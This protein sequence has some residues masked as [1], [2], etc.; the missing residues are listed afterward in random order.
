ML[1]ERAKKKGAVLGVAPPGAGKSRCMFELA[2]REVANGGR[3]VIKAHRKM[4]LDQLVGSFQAAGMDV[5]VISP[6][7][8]ANDAARV[9]I[10]SSQTLFSRAVQ[11]GSISLPEATL[12]IN[13]EAHQ[14]CG[15]MERALMFG[16]FNGQTVQ[17]GYTSM[18][19]DVIGFTATPLMKSRIYT[20]LVEF[21]KYSELRRERMHQLIRVFSPDEIDV[22]GLSPN[23]EG[24]FS[25]KALEERVMLIYGSVFDEWRALNPMQLPAILFAPSVASSR[26]FANQFNDA[27]VPVAHIDGESC[28][29][30]EGGKLVPYASTKE[31][32]DRILAMSKSREIKIVCNRFVLREAIDMP[33]LYHAIFATVMGGLTTYLQSV[34]RL[35]RYWPEYSEKVLQCHGGSYWRHGSPNEDREWRL[36]MTNKIAQKERIER[37]QNGEQ[38]E[39]IR[40]PKCGMWRRSGPVCLNNECK[41]S[42]TQSVRAVRTIKGKLKAMTGQVYVKPTANVDEAQKMWTQQLFIG[43]SKNL[44]VGQCV[45]IYF[46]RISKAGI[47]TSINSLRNAPP[48]RN[49]PNWDLP[50]ATVYPWTTRRRAKKQ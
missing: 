21:G 24:E 44:T 32:R 7:Y 39:G 25:E 19:V 11:R 23:A 18:G 2:I 17:E 15:A 10:V 1:A 12:V 49:S 45:A 31:N 8:P 28:L 9:Q 35:Q 16:S 22:Q 41:H 33:W 27:G 37:I 13:D 36:G 30:S 48:D 47:T 42:H 43:A 50:V 6:D 34:G 40:C 26:W 38:A 20:K 14:Q 29:I 5:G 4:L 46:Q 3:V